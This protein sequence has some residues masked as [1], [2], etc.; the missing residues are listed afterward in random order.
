MNQDDQAIAALARYEA[1]QAARNLLR[2]E[3]D[4]A[5]YVPYNTVA[6]EIS[7]LQAQI[8][9]LQKSILPETLAIEEQYV[10]RLSNADTDL[11]AAE[12]AVRNAVL[13]H[14]ASVKGNTL[15]AVYTKGRA[16]WDSKGLDGYAVAYPEVLRFR[17]V[18]EPSVSIR[19]A[20]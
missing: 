17:S 11:C 16:S 20:K 13:A 19:A 10:D 14:G 18:G 15:H 6:P 8:E 7:A 9:E 2:L 3:Y 4:T 5:R 1:A 12:A